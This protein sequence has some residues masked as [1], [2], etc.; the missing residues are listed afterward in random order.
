MLTL[1]M[2]EMNA[3]GLITLRLDLQAVEFTLPEIHIILRVNQGL[4]RIFELL[5]QFLH[6]TLLPH[7]LCHVTASQLFLHPVGNS[8]ARTQCQGYC[9][10]NASR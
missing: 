4:A 7:G 5:Y 1:Q 10:C 2:C 9:A 3:R 6:R 8:H